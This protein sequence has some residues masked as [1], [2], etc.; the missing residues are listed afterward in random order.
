MI[1]KRKT[2]ATNRFSNFD[3]STEILLAMLHRMVLGA[4]SRSSGS[5]RFVVL[6][7]VEE[8]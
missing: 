5:R 7:F 6:V 1:M 2:E 4:L 8:L 3:S